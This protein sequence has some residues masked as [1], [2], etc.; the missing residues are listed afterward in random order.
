MAENINGD[1]LLIPIPWRFTGPV[2]VCLKVKP[3]STGNLKPF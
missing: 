2:T 3:G 1:L